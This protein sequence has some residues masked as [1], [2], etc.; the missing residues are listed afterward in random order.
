M[1][2]F[3][4]WNFFHGFEN[5]G[6]ATGLVR[7]L[8]FLE[9]FAKIFMGNVPRLKTT[10]LRPDIWEKVCFYV[11]FKSGKFQLYTKKTRILFVD[12]GN[13]PSDARNLKKIK[14]SIA[15]KNSRKYSNNSSILATLYSKSRSNRQKTNK[16]FEFIA[17]Q[18]RGT[19]VGTTTH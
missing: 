11:W 6:F 18:N 1:D 9:I 10:V 2:F 3:R 12:L 16:L 19:N 8:Q 15:L 14:V 5:R 17:I 4:Q 7:F 13:V